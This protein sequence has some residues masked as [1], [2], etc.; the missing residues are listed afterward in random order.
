MIPLYLWHDNICMCFIS[1]NM[2]SSGHFCITHAFTD[3]HTL[4]TDLIYIYGEIYNA[5]MFSWM[6]HLES[7]R[8]AWQMVSLCVALPLLTSL[9]IFKMAT[10]KKSWGRN[11]INCEVSLNS[12][13]KLQLSMKNFATVFRN[14]WLNECQIFEQTLAAKPATYT[15]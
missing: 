8:G 6:F 2:Y 7:L 13:S 3:W 5:I 1:T 15:V 14:P 11:E 10:L 12:T 9:Y 4:I